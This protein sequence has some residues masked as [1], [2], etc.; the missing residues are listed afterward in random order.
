MLLSKSKLFFSSSPSVPHRQWRGIGTYYSNDQ[1]NNMELLHLSLGLH[2]HEICGMY[3]DSASII[4]TKTDF[5]ALGLGSSGSW[6]LS[7]F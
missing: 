6:L 4:L 2:T 3:G 5:T 1:F 7:S